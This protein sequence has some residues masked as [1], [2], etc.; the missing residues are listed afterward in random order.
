MP[1]AAR[2]QPR[3]AAVC[4]HPPP[5]GLLAGWLAGWLAGRQAGRAG[6]LAGKAARTFYQGIIWVQLPPFLSQLLQPTGIAPARQP[7]LRGERLQVAACRSNSAEKRPSC[8]LESPCSMRCAMQHAVCQSYWAQP[9]PSAPTST[10]PAPTSTSQPP[11]LRFCTRP[12]SLLHSATSPLRLWYLRWAQTGA[13]RKSLLEGTSPFERNSAAC[14]NLRLG[15]RRHWPICKT[16]VQ[17]QSNPEPH[18]SVNQKSRSPVPLALHV[19]KLC[20]IEKAVVL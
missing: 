20:G 12:R 16:H 19:G 7:E 1:V 18:A 13:G 8:A 11:H 5:Q 2:L 3:M 10:Q 6:S 15:R 4:T 17:G 14:L 9:Q